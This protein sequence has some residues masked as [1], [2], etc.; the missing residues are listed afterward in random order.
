MYK[1]YG[2][3]RDSTGVIDGYLELLC[4]SGG[5]VTYNSSVRIHMHVGSKVAHISSVRV[6]MH[7]GSKVVHISS[8][9]VHMH[10][11]F[12]DTHHLTHICSRVRL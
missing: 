11:G 4:V 5:V 9:R 10:V 8:V 2:A 3:P 12:K 6:H 7:V 1:A